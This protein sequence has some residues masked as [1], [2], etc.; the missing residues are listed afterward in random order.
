M[1]GEV[2]L[3]NFGPLVANVVAAE[4]NE[5]LNDKSWELNYND[6]NSIYLYII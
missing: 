5:I 4:A 1:L 6:K 3:G 2:A